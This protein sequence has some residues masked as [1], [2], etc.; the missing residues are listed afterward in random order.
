MAAHGSND[1]KWNVRMFRLPLLYYY[2]RRPS[3]P[4]QISMH[5]NETSIYTVQG[6]VCGLIGTQE[7]FVLKIR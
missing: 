4:I 2:S 3:Q 1:V 5:I 7:Q 6:P